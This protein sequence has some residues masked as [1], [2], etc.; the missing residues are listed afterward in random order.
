MV[1]DDLADDEVQE[2]L[3]E[4]RI[5]VGIGG[6][7]AQS[8]Y[9]GHLA[10][11]VGRGQVVLRLQVAHPLG[12]LEPFGEQIHQGGVNVVDAAAH[13]KQLVHDV[14]GNFPGEGTR[15]RIELQVQ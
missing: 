8:R 14:L 12:G 10:A 6:K 7:P 3:R 15:P 9:L 2:L 4:G 11:R 5:Q 13:G 1:A